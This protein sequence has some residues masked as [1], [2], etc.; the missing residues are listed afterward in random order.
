MAHDVF[1]SHST[2]DKPMADAVCAT[3]EANAIRCWI[4]P[5]DVPPG[6]NWGA[7]IVQAIQASRVMVLIFSD[8]ANSSN[9]IAREVELAASQ[10]VTIV[11][12]RVQDVM[13][14]SSLQFFLSNIHWLDALTPP[15]E[16]RLQE[17]AT[18]IKSILQQE[19]T[20]SS[21]PV[22]APAPSRARPNKVPLLIASAGGLALVVALLLWR[23][24]ASSS[25]RTEVT[26][27]AKTVAENP[28]VDPALVG[29]WAYI[30]TFL[31]SDIHLEF[32]LDAA[33]HYTFR[34]SM[35]TDGTVEP[36]DGTA[37]VV[38]NKKKEYPIKATYFFNGDDRLT[39]S[40]PVVSAVPDFRTAISYKRAGGA[41]IA[42]NPLVGKWKGSTFLYNLNWDADWD[43]LPDSTFHVVFENNDE[44][45][46]SAST[47][48]WEAV[49][50]LSRPK[51]TGIY[52]H[53]TSDSFEMSD[54]FFQMLKFERVVASPAK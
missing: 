11:P 53:V 12:I 30:T 36:K 10:G 52:R 39:W 47:G 13:P 2:K 9:Q 25:P 5:R 50:L 19:G 24:W 27:A 6:S 33:G 15:F 16:R 51:E 29:R 7:A 49:S 46:F 17:I 21:P 3:F 38:D 20:I 18:K 4:A 28:A 45:N 44:G 54:R 42:D 22:A 26:A 37:K 35:E 1:I 31:D 14:A 34:R 23:P 48:K 8:H 40:I 41:R 32:T 43:V